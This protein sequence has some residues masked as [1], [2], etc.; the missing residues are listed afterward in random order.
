[1]RKKI[2]LSFILFSGLIF[3]YR[4]STDVDLYAD[5]KDITIVYGILDVSDD[6]SWIKITRAFA[7]PGNALQ[8]AQK[9]DSSNYSYLLDVKIIDSTKKPP[10][11]ISFDTLTITNKKP[12]DS[13]FYYPN[14]L[15][16]FATDKLDANAI[17]TLS[18]KKKNNEVI[19][20]TSLI[21]DFPI[22]SPR[23]RINFGDNNSPTPNDVKFEWT[24]PVNAKRYEVYY[25]FNY[26]EWNQG[27]T[28]TLDKIVT[29][30]VGSTT[31]EDIDGSEEVGISNYDGR[32]F[33]NSLINELTDENDSPGIKRLAG[34][35]DV[36]V[37]AGSQELQNYIA[38]NNA[39]GSLLEEV[40]TYS[41]I[42]N[43]T[44]LFTSR[45][46]SSKSVELSTTTLNYLVKMNLGF[47]LPSK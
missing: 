32:R 46:T 26:Q 9:P 43:G 25:V 41:N 40:P 19:S 30:S 21:K 7:G 42:E 10:V 33:Y 39:S 1:M 31:S 37:A 12:G 2:I 11:E 34:M 45:H 16:Y 28:D 18:I 36:Y 5:Y 24:T 27:S 13:I 20:R 47:I 15:V 23:N 14:Q 22:T 6:T 35:I 38:I 3:L 44:G 8:I 4:C 29:F 17:Y